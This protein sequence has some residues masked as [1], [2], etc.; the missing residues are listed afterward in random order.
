[1][2]KHIRGRQIELPTGLGHRRFASDDLRLHPLKS[3]SL[4]KSR[5]DSKEQSEQ[6]A[7][8]RG[9]SLTTNVVECFKRSVLE[10]IAHFALSLRCIGPLPGLYDD[11]A[12]RSASVANDRLNALRCGDIQVVIAIQRDM[13]CRFD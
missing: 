5:G 11:F 10:L 3:W 2:D 8:W 1:M 12:R 6:Q 13:P 7:G 4:R 9:V